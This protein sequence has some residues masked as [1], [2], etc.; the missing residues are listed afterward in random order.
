MSGNTT[1]IFGPRAAAMAVQ[2]LVLEKLPLLGNLNLKPW[3]NG[4][5]Q[6]WKSFFQG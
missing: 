2:P 3:T 4:F 5:F 1:T 6:D